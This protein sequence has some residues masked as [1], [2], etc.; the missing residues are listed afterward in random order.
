MKTVRAALRHPSTP[1]R[2]RPGSPRIIPLVPYVVVALAAGV[3]VAGL[4]D[5]AREHGDLSNLDP[6]VMT[7]ATGERSPT[8]TTIA[9]A[10]STVGSEA[11]VAVLS[12]V[13]LAWLALVRRE[14]TQA[15]VV[16]ASLAG[17][18]AITVV[19]KHAVG[20]ARP[21]SAVVL[22]PVDTGFS[23]PSGHTL[24]STVFL[25]LVAL[26]LSARARSAASRL[27]LLAPWLLGAATVGASRIYLGYH[28]MTDVLAGWMVG[29][30]VLSLAAMALR[31]TRHSPSAQGR[32]GP[33]LA[34]AGDHREVDDGASA[35]R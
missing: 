16:G 13:L 17:A 12:V 35:A 7:A 32:S 30:L 28:W 14:R 24:L 9:Q 6:Q 18:A 22:G 25:G 8:L 33:R 10:V 1:V 19:L 21:G 11:A 26:L 31:G 20:R 27:A 29:V 34:R 2:R 15:L 23:F 4:A 5:G 3:A